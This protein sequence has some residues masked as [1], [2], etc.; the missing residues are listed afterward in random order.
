[1]WPALAL[2]AACYAT[3]VGGQE[4]T[5]L[6]TTL[7]SSGN[8]GLEGLDNLFYIDIDEPMS[9]KVLEEGKRLTLECLI[10]GRPT[11]TYRWFKDGLRISSSNNRYIITDVDWGNRLRIS[12]TSVADSGQ[13]LCE[14]QNVQGI[15]NT[16]ALITI[17]PVARTSPRPY[18]V[19][20]TITSRDVAAPFCQLYKVSYCAGFLETKDIYVTSRRD[21]NQGEINVIN[22]VAELTAREVLANTRCFEK[23]VEAA[24]YVQMPIC[25]ERQGKPPV[26]R[27]LC[28]QECMALYQLCK[29]DFKD[30]NDWSV[31][32]DCS[33]LDDNA[34][35]IHIGLT[36]ISTESPDEEEVKD[37]MDNIMKVVLPVGLLVLLVVAIIIVVTCI[38]RRRRKLPGN[39]VPSS[40]GSQGKSVELSSLSDRAAPVYIKDISL[41]NI[42]MLQE[43]GESSYG[44]VYHGQVFGL[45]GTN[46]ASTVFIKCLQEKANPE[47]QANF[48]EEM[49]S[50][51]ELRHQH[52]VSLLGIS[53]KGI[54]QCLLYEHLQLGDFRQFL[55][56]QQSRGNSLTCKELMYIITQVASALE[57][58]SSLLYI[59]KD[60][61]AHNVIVSHNLNVKLSN[62]NIIHGVH[63]ANYS[64][65]HNCLLPIRWLPA[66]SITYNKFSKETDVY[67]YG[68][69]MW[70]AFSG[71]QQPYA[72]FTNQ[73]VIEMVRSRQLLACPNQCPSRLY[74]LMVECWHEVPDKRPSAKEVHQKLRAWYL[75]NTYA[76]S[77]TTGPSISAS[78]S[79]CTAP[80]HHSSTGIPASNPNIN[81]NMEVQGSRNGM[82][83]GIMKPGYLK[84]DPAPYYSTID[85]SY[86][87][88]NGRHTP[89]SSSFDNASE[90][91]D[92]TN[93]PLINNKQPPNYYAASTPSHRYASLSRRQPETDFATQ[94]TPLFSQID[95]V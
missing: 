29:D 1:M 23:S 73:E 9:A 49:L 68:V 55:L 60:V 10:T 13:Y 50:M 71:A 65:L 67:S 78:G 89:S 61:A 48:K 87:P 66:E 17:T 30:N 56:S 31:L 64:T 25:V 45:Y 94:T 57:Y 20:P 12:R 62:L 19:Q 84:E 40:N 24:C 88:H 14:A 38:C 63:S 72:S 80:S 91:T 82:N 43:L 11:P 79:T 81:H 18:S 86:E 7:A 35:C 42:N 16:S 95:Q 76:I 90:Y 33:P 27:R 53:T 46:T 70:E 5:T 44:K 39:S 34:G 51:S 58:L 36:V 54:T 6:S 32:P 52:V 74:S 92:S 83:D 37:V 93:P 85:S 26:P 21:Q 8:E 22:M 75:D 3:L 15:K 2:L 69:F 4:S 59:H 77:T 41:D 28:K 47:Q